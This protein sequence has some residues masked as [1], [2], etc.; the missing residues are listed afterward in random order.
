MFDNAIF[1]GVTSQTQALAQL[2]F[3]NNVEIKVRSRKDTITGYK[4][5]PLIDNLNVGMY[6]NFAAD[7]LRWSKL[8]LNGRST[9]FKQL[10]LTYNFAFDPYVIGGRS[11]WPSCVS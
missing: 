4:K 3:G 10:Y 8:T 2:S 9:L 7:S 5:V 11:I 6:Y 1:G